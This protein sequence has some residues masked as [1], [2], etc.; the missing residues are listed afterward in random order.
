MIQVDLITGFLGAGKTTFLKKYTEYLIRRGQ[1]ICILENDF[2]AVNVDMLL[3]NDLLGEN[4]DLEMVAGGCDADCHR[5]RFKTKLISMGMRGFDRVLMEPSGIF[6]MDEF[7]D[8]LREEPLDRWYEIGSVIA[9]VDGNLEEKLS[10]HSEYLLASQIANAGI[11]AISRVQDVTRE[12]L[13]ATLRHVN[14]ALAGIRC[15]EL[16]ERRVL[17]KDWSDFTDS[18]Y[19]SILNA[20]Y[21]TAHFK[22][23]WFD[24]GD[25]YTAK[26]F[27]NY[28]MDREHLVTCLNRVMQDAACGQ[29]HRIK[30]FMQIAENEWVEC[31]V[32]HDRMSVQPVEKGQAVVIVIGENLQE[33][34]IE[35]YFEEFTQNGE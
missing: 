32:T 7:F 10:A 4:C 23:L 17:A 5:R 24:A 18:D 34:A 25:T 29:I 11:V 31:N 28:R 20:G 26:Y 12:Q 1:R 22:K 6:D 2:G 21:Q 19:E 13:D 35:K 33:R 16:S 15:S 27:M 14:R 9:V 8:T 30:G 3:L